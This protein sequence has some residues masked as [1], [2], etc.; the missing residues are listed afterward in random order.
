MTGGTVGVAAN[1]AVAEHAVLLVAGS[2][3][4]RDHQEDGTWADQRFSTET[5]VAEAGFAVRRDV[6]VSLG[7]RLSA[8]FGCGVGGGWA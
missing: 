2:S 4:L 5:V 7:I 1:D 3:H 8:G 6:V